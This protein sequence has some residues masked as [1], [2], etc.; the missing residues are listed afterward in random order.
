M[1][2]QQGEKLE[3]DSQFSAALA[4][5]RFAGSLLEELQENSRRLAAGHRGISRPQGRPKAF[6][7]CKAR[8]ERKRIWPQPIRRL[9]AR[10]PRLRRR[11]KP[12]SRRSRLARPNRSGRKRSRLVQRHRH[13]RLRRRRGQANDKAIKDATQKLRDKVDQLQGELQTSRTRISKVEEEKEQLNSKLRDS[14]AKLEQMQHELEKSKTAESKL[15]QQLSQAQAA[16]EKI[17]TNG[18]ADAKAQQA[19]QQEVGRLKKALAEA[20]ARP[21]RGGKGT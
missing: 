6:C 21:D 4:K 3:R 18:G 17:K 14:N 9:R 7:V 10:R 13:Q 15:N 5:Y 2:A 11:R 20:Q 19:L 1:T 12:V 16:L 8:R